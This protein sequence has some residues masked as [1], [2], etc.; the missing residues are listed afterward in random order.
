VDSSNAEGNAR[1]N[2]NFPN[3]ATTLKRRKR[4]RG[5]RVNGEGEKEERGEE[6]ERSLHVSLKKGSLREKRKGCRMR[7]MLNEKD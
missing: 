7:R 5:S 2:G 6:K 3:E 4:K 1:A